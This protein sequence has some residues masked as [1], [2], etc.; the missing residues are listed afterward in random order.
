[1]RIGDDFIAWL[2]FDHAGSYALDDAGE[3][4]SG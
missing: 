1:M 2:E 4:P 3:I